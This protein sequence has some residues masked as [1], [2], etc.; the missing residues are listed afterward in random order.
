MQTKLQ[1]VPAANPGIRSVRNV[2]LHYFQKTAFER[3]IPV[4]ALTNVWLDLTR[5]KTLAL[6]GPS[7]CGKSS[8]A[9]CLVLLEKP[10]FGEIVYGGRNL[11]ELKPKELKEVRRDIHLI[12]QDSASALN[13][14]MTIEEVLLEPLE[15]HEPTLAK[16]D[17]FLRLVSACEQ[18]ALSSKWLTRR[19]DE[20]SGGQ[21]QRV[22]IARSLVARPKILILDEALS[23]LDLSTQSQ[24]ANLLLDL[25]RENTLT[26]L[27]ISHDMRLAR[28]L[29]H[30]VIAMK[31]GRILESPPS[32][33]L[34]TPDIHAKSP[35]VGTVSIAKDTEN[36]RLQ[37]IPSVNE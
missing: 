25:Q 14:G 26:Y 21:R 12:F 3:R 10:S 6:V 33:L 27:F 31:A 13:P 20:L 32:S 16:K 1:P 17:R 19:P 30:D 37:E 23:A 28:M 8:L 35:S 9:R 15:I 5:G 4:T 22:A 11:L 7:G 29:A 36:I 24:I 18:A 34:L 2:S